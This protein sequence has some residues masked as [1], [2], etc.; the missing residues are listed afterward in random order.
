MPRVQE[1]LQLFHN[2]EGDGARS[3]AVQLRQDVKA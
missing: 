3:L 1:A 2:S